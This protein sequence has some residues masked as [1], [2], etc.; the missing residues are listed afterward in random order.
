[1][2]LMSAIQ[3]STARPG[4]CLVSLPSEGELRLP[5]KGHQIP[6]PSTY[7]RTF[8]RLC[9]D[10]YAEFESRVALNTIAKQFLDRLR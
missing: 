2:G 3:S 8:Y 10:Q 4:S 7:A 1:M 6:G 5:V 9:L